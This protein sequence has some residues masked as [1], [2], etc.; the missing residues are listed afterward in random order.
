MTLA[1]T[2]NPFTASMVMTHSPAHAWRYIPENRTGLKYSPG[3]WRRLSAATVRLVQNPD[4]MDDHFMVAPG[5]VSGPRV[6]SG[7]II[8]TQ[9]E[10]EGA[11]QMAAAISGRAR[12][13]LD[14]AA[15]HAPRTGLRVSGQLA[16]GV[17]YH[18][19]VHAVHDGLGAMV[20]HCCVKTA[21]I[22][23]VQRVMAGQLVVM[24][25][26]MAQRVMDDP[27]TAVA[28]VFQETREPFH[29]LA[30]TPAPEWMDV[31]G[32]QADR[33]VEI[34]QRCIEQDEWLDSSIIYQL[35]PPAWADKYGKENDTG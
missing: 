23:E 9:Q 29:A 17:N 3:Y 7:R 16:D 24:Q 27:A 19:T 10:Y 12:Q 28:F 30:V 8:L 31:A 26:V 34:V 18:Q 1:V 15:E 25:A 2:L 4:S 32:R 21:T 35:A 20:M 6:A 11:M 13:L 22:D 5:Y 14:P 33:C